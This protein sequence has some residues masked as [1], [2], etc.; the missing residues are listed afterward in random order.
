MNSRKDSAADP[1]PDKILASTGAY[2]NQ[3]GQLQKFECVRIATKR[4]GKRDLSKSYLDVACFPPFQEAV[5]RLLFGVDSELTVPGRIITAHTPG[6]TVA[7]RIGANFIKFQWRDISIW[8]SNPT[9]GNHIRVFETAGLRAKKLRYYDAGK[10]E[11]NIKKL[12]FQIEKVPNGDVVF[13]QTSTHTCIDPNPDEWAQLANLVSIKDL[14]PFL[15]TVFFGFSN[16]IQEDLTGL[17]ILS[18]VIKDLMITSS[19]SKS[20]CYI[21]TGL[22]LSQ[23]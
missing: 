2:K 19:F 10:R 18:G 3:H 11:L 4:L 14:L 20:L 15:D 6:G 7:L 17:R 21:T 12:L 8:D 5:N 22:A 9:W 16:G 13:L 23:F 1:R